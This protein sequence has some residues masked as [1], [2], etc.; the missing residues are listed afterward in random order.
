MID[1]FSP[2]FRE[3]QKEYKKLFLISGCSKTELAI[4]IYGTTYKTLK[5]WLHKHT[6]DIV[7]IDN[8]KLTP[9]EF[10]QIL[11][12]LGD[13]THETLKFPDYLK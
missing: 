9:L 11:E 13:P 8:R 6:P 2:V 4:R 7:K 5:N 10:R 3:K 12:R 1:Q